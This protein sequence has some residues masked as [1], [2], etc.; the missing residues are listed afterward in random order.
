MTTNNDKK[1]G[2]FSARLKAIRRS[3]PYFVV[4]LGIM[5]LAFFGSKNKFEEQSYSLDMR[6]L[7]QNNF[8]A[9]ADQT[10][11]LYV[12][13]E[14][15]ISMQTPTAAVISTNYDSITSAAALASTATSEK[16]EKPSAVD[17]TY[18]AVGVVEYVVQDG[19]T[20][21]SIAAKYEASGVTETMIRWSNNFKASRQVR[22][23][24]KIYIPGRAGFVHI[25]KKNENIQTMAH[26]YGSTVEEII[27]ANS[28]E[29][30]QNVAVGTR[31][32]IPN[33]QLPEVERPDYVAPVATRTGR[34][35]YSYAAQYSA[36]N[37][38]AY[39]WCTWYAWSQR[40]DLPSNM[41]NAKNWAN[42][43]RRAGF[44][45]DNNPRAGDVFQTARGGGGY[46]HVGYVTGVNADGSIR[47][48][49]MNG[50]AGWGRVGCKTWDKKTASRYNYIH[51]K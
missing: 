26:N 2:K 5:A 9:S 1:S 43:A 27:A 15:A 3:F 4:F 19:D 10:A 30:N 6:T 33:G 23:G 18:L 39:G 47:I 7:A 17:T 38:Y 34:S 46:G 37:R 35:T 16:L 13:S 42:A 44:K 40:R 31:L 22:A 14:V 32:L 29:L 25:V 28:L 36:G 24:E 20:I 50:V 8:S 48:C 51:K 11:E 49:D 41:G 12:V 45:V 21:A